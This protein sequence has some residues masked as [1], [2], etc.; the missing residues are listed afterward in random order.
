MSPFHDLGRHCIGLVP[1]GRARDLLSSRPPPSADWTA[2]GDAEPEGLPLSRFA[3]LLAL[4]I[5]GLAGILS[6]GVGGIGLI[7]SSTFPASRI[8]ETPSLRADVRHESNA[9]TRATVTPSA[10]RQAEKG[11]TRTA[12][13]RPAFSPR[14]VA[15]RRPGFRETPP[16]LPGAP[17][18][19]L[20]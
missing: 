1:A 10:G 3:W 12:A 16:L 5:L 4:G 13:A 14:K 11:R 6:L 20:P 8:R 2:A 18:P 7:Q 9:S 19:G 17:R 15:E